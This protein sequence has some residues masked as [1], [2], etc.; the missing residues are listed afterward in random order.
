MGHDINDKNKDMNSEINNANDANPAVEQIACS[1]FHEMIFPYLDNN[2]TDEAT[3]CF[4]EHA[5]TCS[6]CQAALEEARSFEFGLI[7]TFV[8]MEPPTDLADKIMADLHKVPVVEF[9]PIPEPIA[10][11]AAAAVETAA[12]AEAVKPAVKTAKT[13]KKVSKKKV[14]TIF[15]TVAAAAVLV[16]LVNLGINATPEDSKHLGV[17]DNGIGSG[18]ISAGKDINNSL[19][20]E[21]EEDSDDQKDRESISGLKIFGSDKRPAS[22]AGKNSI[23]TAS[24]NNGKKPSSSNNRNNSSNTQ[25]SSGNNSQSGNNQ[26]NGGSSQP[27]QPGNNQGGNSGGNSN[28]NTSTVV[29]PTPSYGTETTGT[30]NQRLLAAYDAESIYM[31][32]VSLDNKTVSYYTKIS[33]KI[34]LWKCNL[35]T[36]DKPVCE[37]AVTDSNFELQNTTKTY[38]V[39]TTI[40]S[41]DMT[42]LSMN[43]R[44][45]NIGV[46]VSNLLGNST[47]VQLTP[48]GGG[49]LLAWAPNSS[50]FVYTNSDGDLYV[51]YPIEKRIVMLFDGNVKDVAWGTD[52]KTLVLTN[53]EKNEQLS[54]YTIQVP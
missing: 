37:G 11:P 1:L 48:D 35:E 33:D 4:L 6:E 13:V 30:L 27:T 21:A 53:K 28:D 40:F 24:K 36:A 12:V 10:E 49:D 31:P 34:Y 23:T 46:W 47:L 26:N 9:N 29:L 41:P 54:L 25:K 52:N 14:F 3:A 15:G 8:N 2:L 50:K 51:A 38:N 22:S 20:Q 44:G 5:R 7:G 42:M 45:S 32:S 39:N 17:A 16:F 43:S 18:I 19:L